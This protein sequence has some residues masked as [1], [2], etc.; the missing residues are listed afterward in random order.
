MYSAM[1]KNLASG[2]FPPSKLHSAALQAP[3]FRKNSNL[4]S[5]N[6]SPYLVPLVM[7]EKI[8]GFS[9]Y[10]VVSLNAL[11]RDISELVFKFRN[12]QDPVARLNEIEVTLQTLHDFEARGTVSE[13]LMDFYLNYLMKLQAMENKS[14]FYLKM[15]TDEQQNAQIP[16]RNLF[17][18][19]IFIVK[20]PNFDK[21]MIVFFESSSE[22]CDIL[23]TSPSFEEIS[24]LDIIALARKTLSHFGLKANSLLINPDFPAEP[25][26]DSGLKTLSLLFEIYENHQNLETLKN[27]QIRKNEFLWAIYQLISS[28]NHLNHRKTK[29]RLSNFNQV[30][31]ENQMKTRKKPDLKLVIPKLVPRN[32]NLHMKN[33]KIQDYFIKSGFR[34]Q[35]SGET[36]KS[37]KSTNLKT[38]YLS[39]HARGS[40]L[41]NVSLQHV[42]ISP[43]PPSQQNMNNERIKIS[44]TE[45]K[46]LLHDMK[47][48]IFQEIE[49]KDLVRG[50]ISKEVKTEDSTLKFSKNELKKM[51][52]SFKT[53]FNDSIEMEKRK[54]EE[55]RMRNHMKIEQFQ[56][57]LNYC[58]YYNPEVYESLSKEFS[59]RV[60]DYYLGML[61]DK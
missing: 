56:G 59:K 21:W 52:K 26:N 61:F 15:F 4:F 1:P 9:T 28:Q 38:N 42:K 49:Q 19:M 29:A 53:E 11:K 45:L 14:V 48:S 2:L 23:F 5:M 20:V 8:T 50:F 18:Y 46:G 32:E 41:P 12:N 55:E 7:S 13:P 34:K 60:G 6:P 24:K 47:E 36:A 35:S 43:N 3:L 10:S 33:E 25:H 57:V 39:S 37:P 27:L 22:N 30:A 17:K 54:Q 51:L 58:Y 16:K 40:I 44:K 31:E